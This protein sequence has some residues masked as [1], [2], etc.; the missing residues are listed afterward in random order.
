[1]L[2]G[3]AAI[4]LAGS[5]QTASGVGNQVSQAS[6]VKDRITQLVE[7]YAEGPAPIVLL[8]DPV[9]RR[10]S[11][12]YDGQVDEQTLTA[13]IALLRRTMEAAPGVGVAAPQVG[14]PVQI[15]VLQD[16]ANLPPEYAEARDRYPLEFFAAINPSYHPATARRV[17]FYEGC[18][19]MPG[20]TAVVNRALSVDATYDDVSGKRTYR[21]FTGWQARIVQHETDHLH[22][23][24]YV[25][26]LEPGSLS[27][28]EQYVDL[29]NDPTPTHAAEQLSFHLD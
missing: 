25:D 24:V 22:G 16:P 14:V 7:Q 4:P 8:G 9:L 17:G 26:K 18:L 10:Q 29:W 28:Q 15:A 3:T 1:M 27:T 19:S 2:A 6:T 11:E 13:F 23:T 12:P 21:T 5:V 20:Y